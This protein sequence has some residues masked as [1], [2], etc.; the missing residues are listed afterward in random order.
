[1]EISQTEKEMLCLGEAG[2]LV[3]ERNSEHGD[4][5]SEINGKRQEM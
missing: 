4:S 2:G 5:E 3:C 1:V